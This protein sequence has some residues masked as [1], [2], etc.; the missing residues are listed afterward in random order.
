MTKLTIYQIE[1]WFKTFNKKYFSNNL[2]LPVFVISKTKTALGDF[3][4]GT[5][6]RIRISEF[7]QR[8]EKEYQQTLLHEMIHLWQWQTKQ[9]DLNHGHAFKL[10]ARHINKD[11]WNIKRTTPISTV[12]NNFPLTSVYLMLWENE[13]GTAVAKVAEKSIWYFK[14]WY[15]EYLDGFKVVEANGPLFAK[16]RLCRKRITFYT[17]NDK[18]FKEK[19]EPY[20]IKEHV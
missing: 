4:R 17:F 15:T 20:I 18:E 12:E 8:T 2:K 14:R 7:Y 5:M 16:M 1:Q 11:G 13:R 3:R 9:T 6:P 10:M 19:V